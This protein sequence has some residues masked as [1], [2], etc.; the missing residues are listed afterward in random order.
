MLGLKVITPVKTENGQLPSMSRR[1]IAPQLLFCYSRVLLRANQY[2][3]AKAQA[4]SI[5]EQGEEISYV[6]LSKN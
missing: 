1:K 3:K 6:T 2:T 5:W 4:S